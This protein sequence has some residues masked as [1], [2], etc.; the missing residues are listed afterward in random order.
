MRW[1]L[2]CVLC[3]VLAGCATTDP[4]PS[5]STRPARGDSLPGTI[6]F[7]SAVN[8]RTLEVN[9]PKTSFR[10]N[11]QVAWSASLTG[12]VDDTKV[13]IGITR[14]GDDTELFGYEQFITD[15]GATTLANRMPL[16]RFL[17]QPG[18]YTMRYITIDGNVVAEGD[19]ELVGSN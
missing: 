13:H 1:M 9:N 15:P 8:Q 5:E 6:T 16:G 17:A 11:Q 7:G 12:P 14:S 19:F 18:S 10:L 2:S 4:S 3:L